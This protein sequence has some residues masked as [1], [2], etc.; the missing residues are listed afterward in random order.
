MR[1]LVR[2]G[3]VVPA[4]SR[5]NGARP[6]ALY[7]SIAPYLAVPYKTSPKGHVGAVTSI[8]SS[9]LRLGIRDFR[10]AV[11][12]P[13]YRFRGPSR[14]LWALRTT[15]WLAPAGV[16]DVNAKMLGLVRAVSQPKTKG[17]LF[18]ITI[19]LTP[20]NHG[21]KRKARRTPRPRGKRP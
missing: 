3:L 5:T 9:M 6:E 14:D 4:G 20:L 17:R 11:G 21:A 1:L 15:G 7:K 2:V 19:L 10:R 16:T 8:V 12:Q 18:A 13:G